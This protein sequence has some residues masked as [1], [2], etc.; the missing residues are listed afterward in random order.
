MIV[1]VEPSVPIR[2]AEAFAA[3]R[4]MD[5]ITDRFDMTPD[6]LVGDTGYGSAEM[7]GWLVEERGIA[8]HIPVWDKSKRTDGTFSRSTFP[9]DAP[10]H[11]PGAQGSVGQRWASEGG[12]VPPSGFCDFVHVLGDQVIVGDHLCDEGVKAARRVQCQKTCGLI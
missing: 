12:V 11:R 1:D 7:L 10:G 9:V 8:P 2:T 3:R 4:M 6:K 5:R